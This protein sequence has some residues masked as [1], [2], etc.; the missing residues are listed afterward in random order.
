[1]VGDDVHWNGI[2][3]NQYFIDYSV[4]FPADILIRA[5]ASILKCLN[6]FGMAESFFLRNGGGDPSL[7]GQFL[8]DVAPV[9]SFHEAF[10]KLFSPVGAIGLPLFVLLIFL[11]ANLRPREA[12]FLATAGLFIC[13][14]SAL[15]FSFRHVFH[16]EAFAWFVGLGAFAVA[17]ETYHSRPTMYWKRGFAVTIG[18]AVLIQPN[19]LL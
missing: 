17:I 8:L 3:G 5:Y 12:L 7:P 19:F 18:L 10:L 15:Q 16:L 2:A 13:G 11:T 4:S 9:I 1:M 6:F 14:Y